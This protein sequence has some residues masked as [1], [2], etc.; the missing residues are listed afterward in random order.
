MASGRAARGSPIN[1]RRARRVV[2][3]G[4]AENERGSNEE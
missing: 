3:A 1:S 4:T 2:F